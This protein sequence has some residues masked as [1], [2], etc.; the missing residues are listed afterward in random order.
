MRFRLITK[1]PLQ[2]KFILL[3]LLAIL[4]PMFIVGGCLYYFIFQIMAE[5]LAIPESIAC[6]LFPVVEK[7][8]FLLMVSI[9]PITILLFILAI[10]LTNRLIGPLQRLENDLKKIS[11]G[12]Y[13]IRLKIRKDDDLR[14][15]AEVI[16]KIVDKLEGQRQ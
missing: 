4:L 16:N 9:P 10:I 6:N 3:I 7:I 2:I 15:M 8:N 1:N 12:D 13:S 14:L 5:Q 11:E